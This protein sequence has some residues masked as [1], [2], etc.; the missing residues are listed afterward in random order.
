MLVAR[1]NGKVNLGLEIIRRM[2]DGY[3][4]VVTILQQ[5][6]LS[7]RLTF[8]PAKTLSV[9]T[10]GEGLNG[11]NNLVWRAAELLR[12]TARVKRG[13]EIS[14][15]KRIP[16]AA[17]LGGGSAD[18]AVTLLALNELWGLGWSEADLTSLATGLGSDVAFF[19]TGGTQLATGRGQFVEPLPTPALWVVL[20]PISDKGPNKTKLLYESL[21]SDDFTDGTHTRQL[22]ASLRNGG[23]TSLQGLTSGFQRATLER[24]SAVGTVFEAMRQVGAHPQLCGAGPTVMSLHDTKETAERVA[25][26]LRLAGLDTDVARSVAAGSWKLV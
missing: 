26:A 12:S 10:D 13:A 11:E 8:Q 2:S 20:A 15:E 6:D 7:D 17:G 3:H 4:E 25:A 16:I 24:F 9:V 22:A 21:R 23:D 5:I 14:L 19:L 1:A 18:A